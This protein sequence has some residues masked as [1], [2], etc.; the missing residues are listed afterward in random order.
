MENLNK[1]GL[2][3]F[4]EMITGKGWINANTGGGWKAAVNKI[5]SDVDAGEDVRKIDVPT[6]IR[7]YNNLHPGELAP[8]SLLQ[9]E[10]RVKQAIEQYQS[11]VADPTKYKAPSR[12]ISASP[13]KKD[14]AAKV[15]S[16]LS[17]LSPLPPLPPSGVTDVTVVEQFNHSSQPPQPK[18][19]YLATEANLVMPFPLRP[20]YLAQVVIPRD[21]TKVEAQR[22]CAFIQ[23][24]AQE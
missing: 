22:L 13:S 2:I 24:L 3:Q 10:K 7:R 23:T 11:Y 4:V 14:K 18:P 20:D 17:P 8:G 16:T 15:A 5:L 6:A 19:L 21:M 1:A 12:P 9:Y